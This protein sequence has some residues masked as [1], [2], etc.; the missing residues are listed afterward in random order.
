MKE[1][2]M[3]NRKSICPKCGFTPSKTG[4]HLNK[5]KIEYKDK[6]YKCDAGWKD[7]EVDE[8]LHLNCPTCG[9]EA[10]IPCDDHA[11]VVASTWSAST[12]TADKQPETPV[13]KIATYD[14]AGRFSG[15]KEVGS[16]VTSPTSWST[17]PKP[18]GG[19]PVSAKKPEVSEEVVDDEP[20]SLC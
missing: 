4:Y 9:Y 12:T 11:S 3:M 5:W 8:H 13:E 19:C 2:K 17:T 6:C 20:I 14:A 10:S 15:Y 16:S 7:E 1:N 18:C